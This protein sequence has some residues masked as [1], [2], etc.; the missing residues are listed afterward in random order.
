[1]QS[2][3]YLLQPNA[4]ETRVILIRSKR[5]AI[6]CLRLFNLAGLPTDSSTRKSSFDETILSLYPVDLQ[7]KSLR[8]RYSILTLYITYSSVVRPRRDKYV[9]I[10]LN[11]YY[12]KLK[13]LIPSL[14]LTQLR[15]GN[16]D[17]SFC[18]RVIS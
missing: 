11:F 7:T 18:Y 1:M 10:F 2:D 14:D 12:F 13:I 17:D 9:R 16:R 6:D 4:I 3:V 5:D 8:I 15:A